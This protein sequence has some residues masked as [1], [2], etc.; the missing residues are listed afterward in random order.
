MSGVKTP[1]AHLRLHGK[2][3]GNSLALHLRYLRPVFK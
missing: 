2:L 1:T 3:Q